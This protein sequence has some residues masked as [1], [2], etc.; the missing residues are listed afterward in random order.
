MT[1]R[2]DS[3]DKGD[4]GDKMRIFL[5]EF[6]DSK[7]KSITVMILAIT[8]TYYSILS[9][10][11]W[12]KWDMYD[13]IFPIFV[14]ISSH[15]TNLNL[16]LWE[17]FAHRG[18]PLAEL[19]GVPIWHPLTLFF[20]FF[21]VTLFTIQLYYFIIILWSAISMFL[22]AGIYTRHNLIRIAAGIAY[23][24]SGLFISNAQH[25]TFIM[26][27]S[28][29]PLIFYFWRKMLSRQELFYSAMFGMSFAL[30]VLI[31]YP[32]FVIFMLLFII[33]DGLF[34][35]FTNK[36][37]QYKEIA[38]KIGFSI[39]SC[40]LLS[41]VNIT[42]T[43]DIMNKI[44][45]A[46]VDWSLV[47]R[48]SLNIWNW[49]SAFSP[50]LVPF[51]GQFNSTLDVSMNNAYISIIIM[52]AL[53]VCYYRDREN[54][55]LYAGLIISLLL[56]MGN[57]AGLYYIFYKLVPGIDSFRFPAGLRYF[58]FFFATLIAI[59]NINH[60]VSQKKEELYKKYAITLLIF[61]VIF[62]LFY[63][64]SFYMEQFFTK[65]QFVYI[66]LYRTQFLITAALILLYCVLVW[67]LK[68][69]AFLLF[70][71]V[72]VTTGS[73]TAVQQNEAWTIGTEN[74]P[75]GYD[76]QVEHL[77]TNSDYALTNAY[78][79]YESM[80]SNESIFT[81]NFNNQGYLG[82]FDLKSFNEAKEAGLLRKGGEPAVW[83]TDGNNGATKEA[84]QNV[85]SVVWTSNQFVIHATSNGSSNHQLVLEQT[86]FPGWKVEVNGVAKSIQETDSHTMSVHMDA[87][88]NEIIFKFQP[89][90]IIISFYITLVAWLILAIW[91]LKR[92]AF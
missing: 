67:K 8:C 78:V 27:A 87:G 50:A 60:I 2:A 41:L 71:F 85:Q 65:E 28:M 56:S 24:T 55:Y 47:S 21:G 48:S 46:N 5:R 51:T 86:F 31:S 58:F 22:A 29:L 52:V 32:T 72:A 76:K 84:A 7:F 38:K 33:V 16:P 70:F 77:Y 45:R 80:Y 15:I 35:Y 68:S 57:H 19:I 92:I 14:S 43:L 1:I 39:A 49:F 11:I 73:Y 4:K 89:W 6:F 37:L 53:F 66:V 20:S 44:T 74:R 34:Y 12:L 64:L 25:I 91:F 79:D 36:P 83:I 9:G 18:A 40:L 75:V 81:Q 10:K 23:A 63:G 3:G 13:A 26:A 42:A 69:K 88:E 61:S 59:R 17:P 54:I 82:S 90:K 62:I 30:L